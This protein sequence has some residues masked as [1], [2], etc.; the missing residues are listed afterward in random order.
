MITDCLFAGL[1]RLAVALGS[2]LICLSAVAAGAGDPVLIRRG[3]IAITKSDY[4][5]ELQRIP[6]QDRSVFASSTRR[7]RELIEQML[8][9]R[10]LAVRAKERKLD[11]DPVVRRRL[12]LQDEKLLAGVIVDAV[13]QAAAREFDGDRARFERAAR[14]NYLIDK[15]S[16][17][18]PE[19]VMVTQIFFSA[20][21]DGMEG[22]KKRAEE[23]YTKIHAGA[24]IGDLAASLS[25]DASARDVRGHAGPFSRRDM[26]TPIA[27]VVF[28]LKKGEVS[29]PIKGRLGWY[30][31][32]LDERKPPHTKTFDEAKPEIMAS[33]RTQHINE[34]RAALLRSIGE[35]KQVVFDEAAIEAL[36]TPA[37]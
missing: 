29:E 15:T 16:Y 5:A 6:E 28:A 27:D 12:E 14:E 25:D 36:R 17:T 31:I 11:Q 23:A 32:R 19:T 1:R 21:K 13:E 24:D 7:N 18:T 34:A 35:G 3:D 20:E 8:V 22:A 4:E 9:T 10:E 30:V 26:E 37:R 2:L 33:L